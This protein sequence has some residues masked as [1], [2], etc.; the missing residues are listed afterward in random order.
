MAYLTDIERL[1]YYEGEYLGALDFAAEQDYH[2]D[3]RRRHNVGQHTWGIVNGLDLAQVPN[4]QT[5][6]GLAEV[7]VILQPG[8]AIDGFGREILVLSRTQLTQD[9]FA[10]FYDPNTKANPRN[11][12][13][14]IAYNQQFARASTDVCANRNTTNAFGRV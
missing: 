9:L 6:G 1:N 2:R 3:M 7:D 10:A 4:G 11:M 5:S 13:V 12:Y 8:M 14:W